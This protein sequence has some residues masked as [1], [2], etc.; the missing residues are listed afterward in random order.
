M[1][2]IVSC[3]NMLIVLWKTTAQNYLKTISKQE[4]LYMDLTEETKMI[5][6]K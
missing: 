1:F 4:K 3:Y 6:L 2:L 5:W